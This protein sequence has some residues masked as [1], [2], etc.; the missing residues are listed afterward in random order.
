M[1]ACL[2]GGAALELSDEELRVHGGDQVLQR[3]GA[4]EQEISDAGGLGIYG[5]SQRVRP[6]TPLAA[7]DIRSL[8]D[9]IRSLTASPFGLNLLLFDAALEDVD[10]L[11]ACRPRVLSTAW[12][13]PDQDLRSVAERAHA[14]GALFMHQADTLESSRQEVWK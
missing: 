11:L 8:G 5:A 2:G 12:R 4:R 10:T 3:L 14:S 6:G 7:E 1:S 13:R 9:Q